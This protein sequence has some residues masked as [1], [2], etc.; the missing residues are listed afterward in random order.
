[1]PIIR[2]TLIASLPASISY[3]RVRFT[4]A[5]GLPAPGSP[6]RGPP[7]SPHR[8][9]DWCPEARSRTLPGSW[10]NP[11]DRLGRRLQP[12]RHV[13]PG[14]SAL[15]PG[16]PPGPPQDRTA[17]MPRGPPSPG[18]RPRPRGQPLERAEPDPERRPARGAPATPLTPGRSGPGRVGS[19]GGRAHEY[20][21]RPNVRVEPHIRPSRIRSSTVA[22]TRACTRPGGAPDV[23]AHLGPRPRPQHA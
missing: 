18:P 9:S 11:S 5:R 10:P 2:T 1:M 21:K 12:L 3:P 8:Q 16:Q 4:S 23:L 19:C 14:L 13:G 15:G 17:G 6:W 22:P 20:R 7:T